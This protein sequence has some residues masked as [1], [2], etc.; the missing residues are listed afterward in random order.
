VPVLPKPFSSRLPKHIPLTHIPKLYLTLLFIVPVR[1]L[2]SYK[3]GANPALNRMA[4]R[5]L[6]GSCATLASSVGNL[7]V[8]M[9]LKGEPG[10]V[11]F[12]VCNVDILFTISV[13]HW[14]TSRENRE[15]GS[16]ALSGAVSRHKGGVATVNSTHDPSRRVSAL[17][18][19][20]IDAEKRSENLGITTECKAS[21]DGS[22]GL[23]RV[24]HRRAPSW[25]GGQPHREDEVELNNIRVYTEHTVEVEVEGDD[26][27]WNG[28]SSIESADEWVGSRT[29]VTGQ[30]LV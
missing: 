6:I 26:G 17:V 8:I 4:Y 13:L 18:R 12:L 22:G 20:V 21:P 23:I 10:W 11:C 24:L 2:H 25:D 28:A 19:D 29:K 1:S 9:A 3:T 16:S 15:A 5:S 14:V 7:T 27:K 30:R